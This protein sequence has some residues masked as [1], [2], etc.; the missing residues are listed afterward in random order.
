M[1][2]TQPHYEIQLFF[3][4]LIQVKHSVCGNLLGLPE[5][6]SVTSDGLS[7]NTVCL[8]DNF[9]YAVCIVLE[10]LRSELRHN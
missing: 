4:L 6:F 8:S 5:P 9:C 10:L 1:E 3:L 2:S 7:H